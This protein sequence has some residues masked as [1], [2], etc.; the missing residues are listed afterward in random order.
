[1]I[2]VADVENDAAALQDQRL[3]HFLQLASRF[4]DE[5]AVAF[6][7]GHLVSNSS[8]LAFSTSQRNE[9]VAV[10]VVQFQP[11]DAIAAAEINARLLAQVPIP[12]TQRFGLVRS[13]T[14]SS[15][16]RTCRLAFLMYSPRTRSSER[17]AAR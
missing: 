17:R 8:S 13:S 10:T 5:L 4:T 12:Q 3:Y 9:S 1:M 16:I 6:D 7:E 15:S 14:V 11:G 2:D